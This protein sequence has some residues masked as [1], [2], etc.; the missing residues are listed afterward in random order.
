VL[1]GALV[2]GPPTFAGA[3]GLPEQ[4][5]VELGRRLF[6]DPAASAVGRT[7]CLDCHDPD[8]GFSDPA[9]LS[10]DD[11]TFTPRRSQ[12]LADLRGPLHW[13]GA[14]ASLEVLVALRMSSTGRTRG[15]AF[16]P[17]LPDDYLSWQKGARRRRGPPA[18]TT[19]RIRERFPDVRRQLG[20]AYVPAVGVHEQGHVGQRLLESG[21]YRD[22]FDLASVLT[23]AQAED[24]AIKAVLAY[25]KS[26]KSELAPIDRVAA[27]E[28]LVLE[29][30]ADRGLA[31]FRGRAGCVRCHSL[32]RDASGRAS[33]GDGA[34]H[35][36]GVALRTFDERLRKEERRLGIE[37]ERL[38]ARLPPKQVVASAEAR[39]LAAVR[40]ALGAKE[41]TPTI[42][43]DDGAGNRSFKTPSLRDVARRAPYMHDGSLATLEDV[44]R[45]YVAGCGD[46]PMKDRRLKP[47]QASE[48]DV[49]DLVAFLR[50][51]D[52][53]VR[54]GLPEHPWRDR[55][56]ATRVRLVDAAGAPL[57]QTE[58]LVE[59]AGDLAFRG[60]RA[61][62]SRRLT[63]DADGWIQTPVGGRTH[64]RFVLG[65]GIRPAGGDLVPDVC[66]ETT[67]TF[68]VAG[69]T[70][71][72]LVWTDE[73]PPS[74]LEVW[75]QP[76]G[77]TQDRARRRRGDDLP[78]AVEAEPWRLR[79]MSVEHRMPIGAP[80]GEDLEVV[81]V[82]AGYRPSERAEGLVRLP[83]EPRPRSVALSPE[84]AAPAR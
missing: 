81:A 62:P 77:S 12:P 82:Y 84:P 10:R 79:R 4:D 11:A 68:P 29:A 19:E 58:V 33:L 5:L 46:D 26:L 31:L 1:V 54:P 3:G 7:A 2:I 69:R 55:G 53:P 52:T 83:G 56:L 50:A 14:F 65:A 8:H 49:Q 20:T 28:P 45:H 39:A 16:E 57:A 18:D 74:Q 80:P 76:G 35:N 40:R 71:L 44:V 24:I 27:G 17:H 36:T 51:L 64:L 15:D 41:D 47:F 21:R 67:L 30:A 72:A 75:R 59:E 23:A 22:V 70:R 63:T 43:L 48:Q 6:A 61:G 66:R 32:E 73:E 42:F 25:V 60:A 78:E 9:A 37:V 38:H 34:F 13:D